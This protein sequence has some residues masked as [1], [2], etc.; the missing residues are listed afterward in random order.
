MSKK[1]SIVLVGMPGSGKS[2]LGVLLAKRLAKCFVDTDITL[3]TQL[4]CPLQDFMDEHGFLALR[5]KEE[6]A[7]LSGDY[8]NHVV[9]TGGSAVYSAKGMECLKSQ[10]VCVFLD[11][12]IV[13][14]KERI[15]N[16]ASRGVAAKPGTTLESLYEERY[17][18]Y[19][20]Y[21]DLKLPLGGVG[22]EDAVDQIILEL[23]IGS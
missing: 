18:L 17:P 12:P 1:K 2:T 7:L 20:K 3:Q 10:A 8:D 21:A 16:F 13:D 6:I 23:R 5:E 15:K 4:G 19:E 14:L 9:A 22:T 11:V